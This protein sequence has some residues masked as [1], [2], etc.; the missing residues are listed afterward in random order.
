MRLQS[1]VLPSGFKGTTWRVRTRFRRQDARAQ[2]MDC[3]VPFCIEGSAARKPDSRLNDLVYRDQWR[4]A[5]KQLLD[6]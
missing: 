6:R 2:G 3:G 1:L 4:A 5:M